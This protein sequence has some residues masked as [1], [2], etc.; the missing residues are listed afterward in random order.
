MTREK[1]AEAIRP[2]LREAPPTRARPAPSS[3]ASLRGLDA[4]ARTRSPWGE[5][6]A[7]HCAPFLPPSSY[8]LCLSILVIAFLL[9]VI[10]EFNCA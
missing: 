8:D 3:V 1:P 9:S 5:A 7:H 2:H 10:P 6:R 4:A